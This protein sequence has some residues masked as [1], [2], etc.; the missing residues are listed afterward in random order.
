MPMT[1]WSGEARRPELAHAGIACRFTE[2]FPAIVMDERMMQKNGSILRP[3]ILASRIWRPV[4]DS[5]ICA[6]YHQCDVLPQVIDGD[7]ELIGPMTI[8]VSRQQIAALLG[9]HLDNRAKKGVIEVFSVIAKLHANPAS[10]ARVCSAS[11][12]ASAVIAFAADVLA[13]ALTRVDVIEARKS[14]SACVVHAWRLALPE[15]G[16]SPEVRLETE[17]GEIL[18]K[19][20]LVLG[21]AADAIMV[22]DA[23]QNAAHRAHEQ[24]PRRRSR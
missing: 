6:P 5:E 24:Y 12:T 23:E 22:L 20:G 18:Q 10:R 3:S 9:W 8:T 11:P 2:F 4:D 16:S 1:S 13:R 19:R 15:D 7:R 21:A 14:S 17:P